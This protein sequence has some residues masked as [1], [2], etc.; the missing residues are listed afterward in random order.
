MK[1][2][3]KIIFNF[4]NQKYTIH[5]LHC[6]SKKDDYVFYNYANEPIGDINKE[7]IDVM[8]I[9]NLNNSFYMWSFDNS[10]ENFKKRFNE[11]LNKEIKELEK[12]RDEIFEIINNQERG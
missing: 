9:N 3:Y 10:I 2:I 7:D 5:K 1:Y 11:R 12:Q 6:K 4:H 8:K